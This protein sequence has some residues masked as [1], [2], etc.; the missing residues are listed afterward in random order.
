MFNEKPYKDSYIS[1]H[2]KDNGKFKVGSMVRYI[3]DYF[4]EHTGKEF[5]ILASN[6]QDEDSTEYLLEGFPYLVYESLLEKV[7]DEIKKPT[8]EIYFAVFG[9]TPD[10]ILLI[11]FDDESKIILIT[12]KDQQMIKYENLEKHWDILRYILPEELIFAGFQH[13]VEGNSFS[14]FAI[15]K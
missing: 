12:K 5:K 15:N 7:V 13:A 10:K 4:P 2:T 8:L 3:G 6:V 1:L 9:L 14:S 11:A